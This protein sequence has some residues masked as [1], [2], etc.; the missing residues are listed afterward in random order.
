MR[1]FTQQGAI[2]RQRHRQCATIANYK[3]LK[4]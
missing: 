3:N 2:F 4:R 1:Q